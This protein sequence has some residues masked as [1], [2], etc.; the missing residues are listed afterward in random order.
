MEGG[1]PVFS[2]ALS[3]AWKGIYSVINSDSAASNILKE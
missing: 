1:L 2:V 3:H